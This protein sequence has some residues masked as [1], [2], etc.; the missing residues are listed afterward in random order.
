MKLYQIFQL[1]ILF[2]NLLNVNGLIKKV[3]PTI[4]NSIK[5]EKLILKELKENLSEPEVYP[6]NEY[7][8]NIGKAIDIFASRITFYVYIEKSKF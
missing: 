2:L 8:V 6:S 1:C 7:R 5:Y 4:T 3:K